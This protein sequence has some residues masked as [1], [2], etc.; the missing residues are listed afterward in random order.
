MTNRDRQLP[1]V[2][3]LTPNWSATSTLDNPS[4]HALVESIND[5]QAQRAAARAELTGAPAPN[6]MD[7]AEVYARI[8]SL[9]DR[10]RALNRASLQEFYEELG[11]EMIYDHETGRGCHHP[12][13]P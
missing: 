13:G 8:D 9:S 6:S 12:S 10:G 4:A 5:A 11:L 3:R 7:A 2:A 1:T